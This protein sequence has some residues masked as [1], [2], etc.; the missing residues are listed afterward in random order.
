MT[1]L[2]TCHLGAVTA[3]FEEGTSLN[4]LLVELSRSI[5]R[6]PLPTNVESTLFVGR[7][8]RRNPVCA[9]TEN[10]R[11]CHPNY[12]N[13]RENKKCIH[14]TS[15]KWE[16]QKN[17]LV[18]FKSEQY[19]VAIC[20]LFKGIE[21]NCIVYWIVSLQHDKSVAHKN[22]DIANLCDRIAFRL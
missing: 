22:D 4:T 21:F 20:C 16:V 19:R 5:C 3:L 10:Q 17:W 6:F 11:Y 13:A 15:D 7:K 18:Y 1:I 2:N 9:S 12:N 8:Y 14:V